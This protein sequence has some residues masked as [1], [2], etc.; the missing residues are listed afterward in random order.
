MTDEYPFYTERIDGEKHGGVLFIAGNGRFYEF[1][2]PDEHELYAL[3]VD[4]RDGE[5]VEFTDILDK[6]IKGAFGGHL[7]VNA[8]ADEWMEVRETYLEAESIERFRDKSGE[9]W[10]SRLENIGTK[11]KNVEKVDG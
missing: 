11:S 7:Y 3:F 2:D 4:P 6:D 5:R 8:P 10:E 9:A 1:V